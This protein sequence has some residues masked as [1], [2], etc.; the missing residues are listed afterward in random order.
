MTRLFQKK[1]EKEQEKPERP[2]L[3]S[4]QKK[5]SDQIEQHP[6][7]IG[8]RAFEHNLQELREWLPLLLPMLVVIGWH[9]YRTERRKVLQKRQREML[10]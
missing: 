6:L 9:T 3:N 10:Q 2:L 7:V 4:V 8:F 5:V 1:T